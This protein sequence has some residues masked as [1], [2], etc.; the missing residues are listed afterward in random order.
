MVALEFL[1]AKYLVQ[2]Y[3]QK[4]GLSSTGN[5]LQRKHMIFYSDYRVQIIQNSNVFWKS[6]LSCFIFG[7]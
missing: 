5:C 3:G 1:E 6:F 4:R 7:L 2:Q